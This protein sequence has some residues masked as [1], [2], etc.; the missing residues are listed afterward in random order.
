MIAG[1]V[2]TDPVEKIYLGTDLIWEKQTPGP[3]Y[4]NMPLTF[5]ITAD[6][7]VKMTTAV[8]VFTLPTVNIDVYKNGVHV[9]T[10]HEDSG[11]TQ[12]HS[13]NV[14]S[15]D[16]VTFYGDNYRIGEGNSA[17][18]SYNSS[19]TTFSG[20]TAGLEIEGNIMSIITSTG[21]TDVTS[22]SQYYNSISESVPA[23]VFT[24]LFRK[25]TGLTT[26]ENL[27]L[28]DEAPNSCYTNLFKD[29]NNLTTAPFLPATSLGV[30]SY[31]SMFS[32]CRALNYITCL[33][34]NTQDFYTNR[35]VTTWVDGVA[36][37]GTFV[38][39]PNST[40]PSGDI[41]YNWTIVDY[42]A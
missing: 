12:V 41:P 8:R 29:S 28:P 25:I 27:I 37:A 17:T 42:S 1:Y 30:W 16:V 24:G 31:G 10:W 7:V 22:Y 9:G 40:W 15:G 13:L 3:V 35:S 4:K 33:A 21:F 2:G 19:Y 6:G 32:G 23:G 39:N 38:K 14:V 5:K 18:G 34:A 20:T 26:A 11:N 36:T